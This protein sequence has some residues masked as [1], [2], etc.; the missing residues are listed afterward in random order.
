VL[1]TAA[2]PGGSSAAPP[3][4]RHSSVTCSFRERDQRL[5]VSLRD[6]PLRSLIRLPPGLPDLIVHEVPDV[7]VTPRVEIERRIDAITVTD[8]ASS[9]FF[10]SI[11]ALSL[12]D[13][14]FETERACGA[15]PA[16]TAV[17]SIRL[18]L[19]QH[20]TAAD[21]LLDLRY[22]FLVPGLTDEGDGSSEIEVNA[23]VGSGRTAVRLTR[24][25]DAT[26]VERPAEVD[27]PGPVRVNLNA[28]EAVPDHDLVVGRHSG[29]SILGAGGDDLLGSV[30]GR[31]DPDV[32]GP[33]AI[34][35][36]QGADTL[37]GGPGGDLLWGGPGVD[38]IDAGPGRDAIFAF[39]R[40]VDRIDCGPGRDGVI[41]LGQRYHVPPS[42]EELL[43]FLEPETVVEAD[44]AMRRAI[45][46]VRELRR[47]RG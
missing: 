18:L 14:G 22:G 10:P 46:A 36:G 44:R 30:G 27:D 37:T 12:L 39:E 19:G 4:D 7:T 13:F 40:V 21:L 32:I 8:R 34:A 5:D 28:G 45:R 23:R 26:V 35:G 29:V 43:D 11:G 33:P 38:T 1:V 41:T 31:G 16:M 47:F 20:T 9:P 3:P 42:C 25:A 2:G 24:D 15:R 17:D 6:V